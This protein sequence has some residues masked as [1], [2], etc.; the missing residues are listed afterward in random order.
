MNWRHLRSVARSQPLPVPPNRTAIS[1]PMTRLSRSIS[2]ATSAKMPSSPRPHQAPHSRRDSLHVAGQALEGGDRGT[3]KTAIAVDTIINQKGAGVV[4]VYV[5]IGQKRSTVA[6]VVEKFKDAGAMEYTIVV[7]A[8]ASEPA[9]L[10]FIAPY[11]VRLT[12]ESRER[13]IA[14]RPAPNPKA[15][16]VTQAL[17]T[18]RL[19]LG[20]IGKAVGASRFALEKY[21]NGQ[22]PL[23]PMTRI[24]LAE[25]LEAHARQV[26]ADADALRAG[27]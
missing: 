5:A 21:R 7:V 18:P 9:P 14:G 3:G 13:R 25:F 26:L 10:Q 20:K 4:C 24:R 11:G 1:S 19:T 23:T 22:R 16:A 6:T 12:K 8:S 17:D 27:G 15:E 2:S